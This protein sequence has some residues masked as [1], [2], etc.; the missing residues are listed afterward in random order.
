MNMLE[1]HRAG[2]ARIMGISKAERLP[3]LPDLPTFAESGIAI[4]FSYFH[5][6]VLLA[7][8]QDRSAGA[9][10]RRKYDR[11][12]GQRPDFQAPRRRASRPGR[13]RSYLERRTGLRL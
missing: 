8:S 5:G 10:K 2:T 13:R 3:S 12:R 1:Q 9:R 7:A 11:S 4:D 6:L